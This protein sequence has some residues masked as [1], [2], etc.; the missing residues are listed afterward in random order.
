MT[1]EEAVKK[2]IKAYWESEEGLKLTSAPNHKYN[3]KYFD[4]FSKEQGLDKLDLEIKGKK[5][6]AE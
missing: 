6:A 1:F 3:K 4:D 5:N 2:A